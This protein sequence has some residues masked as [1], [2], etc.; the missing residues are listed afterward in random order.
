MTNRNNIQI[1]DIQEPA[2]PK[3][4]WWL[5]GLGCGAILITFT[6]AL[7]FY[8]SISNNQID[9]RNFFLN[10]QLEFAANEA[11][12]YLNN[13]NEDLIFF[14][15]SQEVN[16][17][18]GIIGPYKELDELKASRLFNNYMN[19]IDTLIIKKGDFKQVYSVNESNQLNVNSMKTNFIENKHGTENFIVTSDKQDVMLIVKLNLNKYFNRLLDNYYLGSNTD[20]LVYKNNGFFKINGEGQIFFQDKSFKTKIIQEIDGGI[21]GNYSGFISGSF[22]AK[23]KEF[24]LVQ[25]PF[26]LIHLKDK[27]AFAFA[28]EK[29]TIDSAIF[30]NYFHLFIALFA[31]LIL[32]V[33]F[34]FKYFKITSENNRFL[35]KK[36]NDLNQLLKQQTILLQQSKGFIYYQNKDDIIYK[37]SEN[38][39]E[40]LG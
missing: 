21:R 12:G 6:L 26:T 27:F 7:F 2:E 32:A 33:I 31:L 11:Q 4:L 3:R 1:D 34:I 8:N 29:A 16:K 25:Y 24:L 22:N 37:V 40:V 30:E 10:K 35:E 20:K 9:N 38:V 28:Q 14:A 36:P 5:I 23:P 15:N 18:R 13:L 19:L 17:Q 39:K